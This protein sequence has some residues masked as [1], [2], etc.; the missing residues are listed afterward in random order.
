M[1]QGGPEDLAHPSHPWVPGNLIPYSPLVLEVLVGQEGPSNLVVLGDQLALV[2]Q[3]DQL[4][5]EC[6]EDL[7]I[8]DYPLVPAEMT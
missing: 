5:L 7:D 1:A 4:G 8:L 2:Y 6:Q 3:G